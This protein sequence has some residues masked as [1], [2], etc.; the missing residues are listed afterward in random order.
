MWGIVMFKK[1]ERSLWEKILDIIEGIAA[2]I[3]FGF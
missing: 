3:A 1:D 2:M